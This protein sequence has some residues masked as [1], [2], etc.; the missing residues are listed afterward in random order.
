M[1]PLANCKLVAHN[2]L[3]F[4][5]PGLP[6]S[7]PPAYESAL[8]P[9]IQRL[10]VNLPHKDIWYLAEE[11]VFAL[12]SDSL[13]K[14]LLKT[15]VLHVYPYL[16]VLDLPPFLEAIANNDGKS[17][18]SLLL[19]HAAMFSSIAF[20]DPKYIHSAGYTSRKDARQEF[21]RKARILYDLDVEQ[22]RIVLIQSV[23]LLTYCHETTYDPKDFRHWLEIA[24]SQAAL[25][26]FPSDEHWASKTTSRGLWKRIWWCIYTRDRLIALILRR[27]TVIE[28]A[29]FS[30]LLPTLA[31]FPIQQ[32]P[33][34]VVKKLGYCE[35]LQRIDYQE[36]LAQIF[37]EK[38]KLCCTISGIDILTTGAS[39]SSPSVFIH[40]INALNGWQ[41]NLPSNIQ[42][43]APSSQSLSEGEKALF[44][45]RAW[46][47]MI[48]LA[49]SRALHRHNSIFS[50]AEEFQEAGLQSIT[51]SMAGI[52]EHLHQLDLVSCLPTT[53][54]GL[55][56]PVLAMHLMNIRS[57]MPNLWNN[58]FKSLYQCIK[59]LEELGEVYIMAESMATFFQSTICGDENKSNSDSVIER[60]FLE[61]ILTSAELETFSHLV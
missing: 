46:L 5:V 37:V 8:P 40:Y 57:G 31:D 32:Y 11:G 43:R 53:T 44:M 34:Q 15:F 25:V 7:I 29:N 61:N 18:V 50:N 36:Q 45:Y 59:I 6:D 2:L 10:P 22:D 13:L 52:A 23:L 4:P 51:Q 27:A 56:I 33:T 12:P 39:A 16:P 54:V 48:F 58:A 60:E 38:T 20:V 9:F 21:F 3:G 42:Y 17:H 24:L 30:M 28:E 35:V 41:A 47:K 49:A 1:A 14:E 26:P 19:F 55:L